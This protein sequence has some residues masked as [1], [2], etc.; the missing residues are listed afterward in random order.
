[1]SCG[2]VVNSLL[3]TPINEFIYSTNAKRP[4]LEEGEEQK[5]PS[6]EPPKFTSPLKSQTLVEGQHALLDCKFSPTDDPNLKVAW[7]LNGK[8]VVATQRVTILNEFGYSVLEINPVTVF[9]H[10]EY[11]CIAVNTLGEV[12]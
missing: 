10:G 7:L 4:D 5:P 3:P 1:L 11:T 9:D 2:L 12:D 8:P 6:R